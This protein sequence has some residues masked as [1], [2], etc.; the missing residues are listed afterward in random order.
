MYYINRCIDL[1]I[2]DGAELVA[3]AGTAY[4]HVH[5]H[6]YAH[7]H[8]H[9]HTHTHH[10]HTYTKTQHTHQYISLLT[11]WYITGFSHLLDEDDDDLTQ[12]M[13]TCNPEVLCECNE[14]Q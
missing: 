13:T 6:T 3:I 10:T 2:L 8:A 11:Y 4:S 7:M 9:T 14:I 5:T 1:V 12:G